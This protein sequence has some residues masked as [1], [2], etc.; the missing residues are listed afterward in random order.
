MPLE[1]R[2]PEPRSQLSSA[3]SAT[4]NDDVRI[5]PVFAIPAILAEL[6]VTPRQAFAKAGVDPSLFD[7][8][9]RRIGMRALGRLLDCCSAMTECGHFGLLV[10]ERFELNGLG[11]IGYLMRNSASIGEALRGLVMHLHLHD[12]GAAPLLLTHSPT[13]VILGYSVYRHGVPGIEQVYDGAIAIGYRIMRE[14]CGS[15]WRPTQV[16]FSYARPASTT[17]HRRLFRAPI[18]FD[19]AVS[20]VA[21]PASLLGEPIEGADAT[22]H[23]ILTKVVWEEENKRSTS[24]AEQVQRLLPQ[25]VLSG[26]ANADSVSNL[27]GIHRRTLQRRLEKE[28]KSLLKLISATRFELA[29]QLLE[30]TGLSV[31]EISAALQYADTATFSR[32]FKGWA[33]CSPARWRSI[34]AP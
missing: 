7:D 27:F 11:A 2:D 12:T 31:T 29:Q 28:G 25:L 1:D 30:N 3:L 33:G 24:F 17:P 4:L 32:A 20:G 15:S 10:G 23:G 19:A 26:A 9:D 22:L 21:F 13:S 5:G 18:V 8:P 6:G 16:Q 34:Q 14:I